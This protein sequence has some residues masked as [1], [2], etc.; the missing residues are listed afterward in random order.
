[1]R[2]NKFKLIGILV[3]TFLVI[4]LK[5]LEA[6]MLKTE[7]C[8]YY[9]GGSDDAAYAV[10]VDGKNN[11]IVTGYSNNGSDLDALT[12]KYDSDLSIIDSMVY[13]G[14]SEYIDAKAYKMVVDKDDNII[15]AG[16][17][18]YYYSWLCY[19]VKYD[20][21]LRAINSATYESTY[22]VDDRARALAVDKNNNIIDVGKKRDDKST[23]DYYLIRY[24]S[25]LAKPA[26]A[27]Y[28]SGNHDYAYGVA[29]DK[30][31][32]II[33]AGTSNNEKNGDYRIV[34]YSYRDLSIMKSVKYD[35]G[36]DDQCRGVAVDTNNNII[37]TG[38]VYTGSNY[39]YRT[40]KYDRDLNELASVTYDSGSNDRAEGIAIDE[41]NNIIIT[42]YIHNGSDNDYHTIIYGPD[43]TELASATYDSKGDDKAYGVALDKK[44]DIIVVGSSK[45]D[46]CTI[47]YK[48]E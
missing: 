29:I 33:V 17:M 48:I 36:D 46:Y 16:F 7:N 8:K 30:D 11:I 23:W 41:N 19:I 13:K 5:I 25:N 22:Y 44:G 47:K 18:W 45:N 4:P 2:E 42:G 38:Y 32:N 1:M 39:D 3:L 34:K 9:D 24:D 26:S 37:V 21:D 20:S 14:E 35:S 27:T 40:I 31:N 28:D 10:A 6:K 15:V 12:I 43:L